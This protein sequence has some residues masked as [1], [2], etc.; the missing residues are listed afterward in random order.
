MSRPGVSGHR[1]ARSWRMAATLVVAVAACTSPSADEAP[2]A[3]PS[4]PAATRTAVPTPSTAPPTSAAPQPRAMASPAPPERGPL[5]AERAMRVTTTLAGDIGERPAGT[6][7]DARARAVVI[8]SFTATGWDVELDWFDL[9]HGGRSANVVASWDGRGRDG[10]PH[11][12]VGGHLDTVP[13]TVGANDNASGIGV[14]AA[15]AHELADEAATLPVPVVLVTFGAEEFQADT[16]VHHVGSEHHAA[17]APAPVAM[18]SV[19]MVGHGDTTRVVSL[20]GRDTRVADRIRAAAARAGLDG[21]VGGVRGDVSDHGPFALRGV[22]A[23]WLWTGPDGRLHTPADTLEHVRAA[24]LQR[25]G[26]VALAWIRD[27]GPQDA[28]G[29]R[30]GTPDP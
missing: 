11:V 9:P 28:D 8:A 4:S 5:D 25:T 7:E 30:G 16:G 26:D 27:L 1:A 18:L 24:D 12:V 14:I 15:M 23:A 22:P 19:D 17:S 3:D 6:P 20:E 2:P 29:L 21:V 10:G 13:G